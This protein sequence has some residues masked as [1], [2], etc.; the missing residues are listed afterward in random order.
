VLLDPTA[1]PEDVAVVSETRRAALL[2][3]EGAMQRWAVQL[4][5]QAARQAAA[6]AALR[7]LSSD[8]EKQRVALAA[9]VRSSDSRRGQ[10]DVLAAELSKEREYLTALA[11]QLTVRAPRHEGGWAPRLC[12]STVA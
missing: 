6:A 10:L 8:V 9:D 12:F 11:A 3:R 2:E 1:S 7:T 4:E 5:L